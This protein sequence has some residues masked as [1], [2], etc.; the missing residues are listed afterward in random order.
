MCQSN[1]AR[2]RRGG[3]WVGRRAAAVAAAVTSAAAPA[4]LAQTYNSHAFAMI[5]E[6]AAGAPEGY[7][8]ALFFAPQFD[9]VIG[10]GGHV[11]SGVAIAKPAT[12]PEIAFFA[13]KSP[14]DFT[15]VGRSGAE[16]P[17]LPGVFPRTLG[18]PAV[19]NP[20]EGGLPSTGGKGGDGL[21]DGAGD[22]EDG[23]PIATS[24]PLD[25][26]GGDG[27]VDFGSIFS[28]MAQ[29]DYPGWAVLEWECCIKHPEQGAAE[30]AP[31]IARHII[32][33]DEHAFDDFVKSGTSI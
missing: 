27:Q 17:G 20:C 30:G 15:L 16:L 13:G 2:R 9:P 25:G 4:A 22:G 7:G 21:S 1:G 32:Q 28:K 33:V 31:F 29:Y 19:V 6:P 14:Q 3:V 24:D 11:I 23:Q 8:Y 10:R 26:R 5:N 12:P 18:G